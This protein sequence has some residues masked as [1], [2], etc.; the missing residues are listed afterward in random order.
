MMLEKTVDSISSGS[1][2]PNYGCKILH[3]FLVKNSSLSVVLVEELGDI[4]KQFATDASESGGL[5][6]VLGWF[7]LEGDRYAIIHT[8]LST[9]SSNLDLI[10]V[11]TERELQ[12][13]TL[14]ASGCSNKQI[15]H[16]LGISEWTVSAHLRRIFIKLNVDSRAAMVYCCAGLIQQLR[17]KA[18]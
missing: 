5:F 18:T 3:Q 13:A 10:Q 12:I 9:E 16:Q 15:A 11:L 4:Q 8:Q 7:D 17:Q 1:K 6:A 2:K 14:V